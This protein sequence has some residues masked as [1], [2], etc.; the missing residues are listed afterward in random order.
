MELKQLRVFVAVAKHM[1]FSQAAK[2]LFVSQPTLSY[3]ISALEDELNTKLFIRGNPNITLTAKGRELYE[4]VTRILKELDAIE[5]QTTSS[6]EHARGENT[7]AISLPW[8]LPPGYYLAVSERLKSFTEH[9]GDYRTEFKHNTFKQCIEDL[10]SG[11]VALA[12][13][14]LRD[15]DKLPTPMLFFPLIED[16]HVFVYDKAHGELALD[17]LSGEFSVI[18][19]LWNKALAAVCE[20][21]SAEL[22]LELEAVE[23]ESPEEAAQLLLSGKNLLLY[24]LSEFERAMRRDFGCIK[25]AGL[26]KNILF[27]TIWNNGNHSKVLKDFVEQL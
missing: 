20:A 17:T 4:T 13:S 5:F 24:P 21:I 23:A 18:S 19:P 3:Q 15:K 11:T 7:L 22:N 9:F 6:S 2:S 27:G 26:Q 25:L 10:G 12:F 8:Q 1:S 16:E 14:I